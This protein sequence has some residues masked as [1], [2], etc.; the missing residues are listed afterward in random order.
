MATAKRRDQADRGPRTADQLSVHPE[1]LRTWVRQTEI[2]RGD[3]PGTRL[4]A[5]SGS[6]T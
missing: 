3:R 2:V 5:R 6:P 1:A 4:M